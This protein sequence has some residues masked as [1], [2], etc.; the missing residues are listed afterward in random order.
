MDVALHWGFGSRFL[1]AWHGGAPKCDFG[2]IFFFFFFFFRIRLR[3]IYIYFELKQNN[4]VDEFTNFLSAN[5][6]SLLAFARFARA[7]K[8]GGGE[9]Y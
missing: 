6:L 9:P 5:L 8:W 3:I 2:L 7:K 4:W 1:T